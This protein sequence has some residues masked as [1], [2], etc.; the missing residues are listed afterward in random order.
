MNHA[1]LSMSTVVPGSTEEWFPRTARKGRLEKRKRK[2][3]GGGSRR[4]G[5]RCAR[6]GH[7]QKSGG[8]DMGGY[9][10]G[11]NLRSA[12]E[13]K[14]Y[15]GKGVRRLWNPWK[16]KRC[17]REEKKERGGQEQGMQ[18]RH[19]NTLI[20][21]GDVHDR[22]DVFSLVNRCEGART[23]WVRRLCNPTL[24]ANNWKVFR[25]LGDSLGRRKV[26]FWVSR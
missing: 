2:T 10:G 9:H 4:G 13:S 22:V 16:E 14:G 3:S 12:N 8:L 23:C 19:W 26:R 5:N 11:G 15:L 18:R 25:G 24:G 21:A 17:C 20:N 6:E 1:S 7:K